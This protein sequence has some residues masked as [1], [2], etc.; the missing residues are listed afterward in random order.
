MFNQSMRMF[1]QLTYLRMKIRIS[2]L[3]FQPDLFEQD[4]YFFDIRIL[5]ILLYSWKTKI[6]RH[7]SSSLSQYLHSLNK[8]EK[9]SRTCWNDKFLKLSLFQKCS[10]MFEFSTLVLL[11]R[12]NIQTFRKRTKN[13]NWWFRLT[14]IMKR[15]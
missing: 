13:R 1:N 3:K 4:V 12:W 9:K 15:H 5:L 14:M 11:M 2:H 10:R 6:I 8:D 7:S